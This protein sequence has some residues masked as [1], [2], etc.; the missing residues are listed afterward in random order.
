MC[1]S[2]SHLSDRS[3]EHVLRWTSYSC[4]SQV[5]E[6]IWMY[7]TVALIIIVT[8]DYVR[9]RSFTS[10]DCIHLKHLCYQL[11]FRL[12]PDVDQ[13]FLSMYEFVC[14]ILQTIKVWSG[15]PVD[16]TKWLKWRW[17]FSKCL[18]QWFEQLFDHDKDF[19]NIRVIPK[20]KSWIVILRFTDPF[21]IG[22]IILPTWGNR[23][24]GFG[25]CMSTPLLSILISASSRCGS[26][27]PKHAFVC[28]PN[29]TKQ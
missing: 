11:W 17:C 12:L 24:Y 7:C 15:I 23:Y 26:G 3:Y 9:V 8:F 14:P 16:Y 20:K 18:W 5:S 10:P 27:L 19:V 28:T 22:V 6:H 2:R 29:P 25:L 4:Y 1:R 13:A 21:I